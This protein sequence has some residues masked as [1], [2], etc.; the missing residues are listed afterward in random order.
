MP[1]EEVDFGSRRAPASPINPAESATTRI[2]VIMNSRRKFRPLP[3]LLGCAL[4]PQSGNRETASYVAGALAGRKEG[5]WPPGL[6]LKLVE[7]CRSARKG[8]GRPCG[9]PA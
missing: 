3:G 6:L 8:N 5:A 1:A 2:L 9:L 4:W 7:A